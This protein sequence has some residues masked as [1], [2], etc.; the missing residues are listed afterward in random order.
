MILKTLII[1][2]GKV[3]LKLIYF[4]LKLLPTKKQIVFISMQS[5][6]PSLDFRFLEEKIT[7]RDNSIKLVFLCKKM[8][9]SLSS[10]KDYINYV[11]NMIGYV[12]KG[13]YYLA[14]S[15]V[16]VTESYCVPISL[17]NN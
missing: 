16:C 14:T 9:S 5:N 4:L 12:L 15:K 2:L 17:L 6:K 13:M 1:N 8:E 10:T 3:I 7:Q 11:L